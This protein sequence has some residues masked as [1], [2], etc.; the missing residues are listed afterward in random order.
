[1]KDPSTIEAAMDLLL[2][3][4]ESEL[5]EMN[6]SGAEALSASNYQTATDLIAKAKSLDDVRQK[7]IAIEDDISKLI[8]NSKG[9]GGGGSKPSGQRFRRPLAVLETLSHSEFV[10]LRKRGMTNEEIV[11]LHGKQVQ[12]VH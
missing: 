12:A 11:R 8:A 3:A 1:M 7:L 9:K 2:E 4:I 10:A 6:R 5:K